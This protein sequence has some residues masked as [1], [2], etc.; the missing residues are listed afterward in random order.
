MM[1]VIR[2]IQLLI[3]LC[4][5][6]C[7]T[8][9]NAGTIIDPV[10]NV[11]EKVDNARESF[12][13]IYYELIKQGFFDDYYNNNMIIDARINDSFKE[14]GKILLI[15]IEWLEKT[16]NRDSRFLLKKLNKYFYLQLYALVNQLDVVHKKEGRLLGL[17]HDLYFVKTPTPCGIIAPFRT[18]LS[19]MA[20]L[21]GMFNVAQ[22]PY[23]QKREALSFVLEKIQRQLLVK[24][25]ELLDKK[26]DDEKIKEFVQAMQSFATREPLVKPS[27][28]KKIVLT[29]IIISAICVGIYFAWKAFAP[30]K[31]DFGRWMNDFLNPAQRTAEEI[32]KKVPNMAHEILH[33][34]AMDVD[35]D[36][37][38]IEGKTN[39]D[40]KVIAEVLGKG[41]GKGLVWE[42][43]KYGIEKGIDGVKGGIGWVGSQCS[44][45]IGWIRSKWSGGDR[46]AALPDSVP[47]ASVPQ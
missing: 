36:G 27:V 9:I 26:I 33:K 16:N 15:L 32:L 11:Q 6:F 17:L 23:E 4:I 29:T 30:H 5:G 44:G 10:F 21:I 24:N 14:N 41:A 3:F 43:P 13:D 28:V 25:V 8:Q 12:E 2:Y 37:R 22:I 20:I 1:I 34:V 40:L 47:A 38:A 39:P 45:G 35:K 46:G 31:E 19:Q 18:N 7:F 42:L